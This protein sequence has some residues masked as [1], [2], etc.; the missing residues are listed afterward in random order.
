MP[1]LEIAKEFTFEAAHFL[2]SINE[3][4]HG[5]TYRFRIFVR[6]PVLPNGL[7]MNFADIKEIVHEKILR[8]LDNSNLNDV[9]EI[10]SSEHI[11]LWIWSRLKPCL[12]QL[13]RIQLWGSPGSMV[14][15]TGTNEQ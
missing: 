4:L 15:Y 14:V 1:I 10:S 5:H 12:P 11:V 3:R 7:V 13:V 9:M 2:P 6:G 8:V